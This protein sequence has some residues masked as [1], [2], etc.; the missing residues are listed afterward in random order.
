MNDNF[1]EKIKTKIK[2]EITSVR[3]E[4]KNRTIG[5]IVTAMGL[6]AGLAWN[7][8]I[9]SAIEHFFPMEQNGV[10]AKFISMVVVLF[11]VYL[12]R[13]VKKE[14]KKETKK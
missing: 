7:D 4:M 3:A 1:M 10:E 14:E 9:K 11:S 13:M 5:Y 8:A 6:V 12:V 2:N